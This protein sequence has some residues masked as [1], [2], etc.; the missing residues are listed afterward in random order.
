MK[1][2]HMNFHDC[3]FI[4]TISVNY[5]YD[6]SRIIAVWLTVSKLISCYIGYVSEQTQVIDALNQNSFGDKLAFMLSCFQN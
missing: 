1:T 4:N 2:M 5:P 6:S 3:S